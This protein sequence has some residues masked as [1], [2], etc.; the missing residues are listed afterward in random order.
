MYEPLSARNTRLS[1]SFGG[2]DISSEL[3]PYLLSLTF[4]DDTDDMADD[5]KITLQDRGKLWLEHWLRSAVEAAASEKLAVSASI[6]PQNWQ[7]NPPLHTG[8]F[9]L[10]SISASG[11]PSVIT[12]ACASLAFSGSLRQT[13]KYKVWKNCSLRDIVQEIT[14]RAGW[15]CMFLSSHN[16]TYD[17]VEQNRQSDINFLRKLCQ[18]AGISIKPTD[19][20]IVL[21]EQCEFEARDPVR[22]IRNGSN[23]LYTKFKLESGSAN[24]RYASCRVR[25]L[26]PASGMCIE[27]HA[28][29]PDVSG[30]QCL[31]LSAKVASSGEADAYAK[32]QLRLHNK[33]SKTADF[34]F[35]GDTR[36]L[37]GNTV[38]LQ[39]WGGWNGKYIITQAIHSVSHSGYT[40]R[41]R[42]RKGL[43]Y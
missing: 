10:D 30:D 17:R 7:D 18:D 12:I 42:I 19:G 8:A 38:L 29:D 14:A 35:P 11:P 40:T 2:T 15:N 32:K 21:Y 9:E 34:T 33:F 36:L 28:E 4:T 16:P 25:Y 26:N 41:I 39:D 27:G 6:L 20:K 23:G 13:K 37:A 3:W 22:V 5:L 24:S 31:E 1:V 43:D